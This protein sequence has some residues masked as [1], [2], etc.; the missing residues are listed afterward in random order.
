MN[1]TNLAVC[2]SPVIF[3]LE[4][5][6]KAK[7]KSGKSKMSIVATSKKPSF[8]IKDNAGDS[9][10]NLTSELENN[11]VEN[12]TITP[13]VFSSLS[14]A[15]DPNRQ[16]LDDSFSTQSISNKQDTISNSTYKQNNNAITTAATTPAIAAVVYHIDPIAVK[17]KTSIPNV[18]DNEAT[19][20]AANK[21]SSSISP[22][23]SQQQLLQPPLSFALIT[24]SASQ[25]SNYKRKCSDTINKA[26]SSIKAAASTTVKGT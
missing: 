25:K 13:L 10:M 11:S 3:R 19:F 23:S 6:S 1:R 15:N 22:Q 12:R 7:L 9:D 2:F 14:A 18:V 5:E 24:S 4:I 21:L 16:E 26:A 8:R 20:N 17:A